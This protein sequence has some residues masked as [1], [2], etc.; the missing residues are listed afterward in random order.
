MLDSSVDEYVI[1]YRAPDV[2]AAW[3]TRYELD[4]THTSGT[5][6]GLQAG[7]EYEFRIRVE[8][9]AGYS[10]HSNTITVNTDLF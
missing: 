1:E 2:S 8:T 3:S 5:I 9:A 6:M 4:Y 7:T 10:A